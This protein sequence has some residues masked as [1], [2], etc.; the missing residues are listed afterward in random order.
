M[1]Q[2]SLDVSQ[3]RDSDSDVSIFSGNT[4]VFDSDPV[5][6]RNPLGRTSSSTLTTREPDVGTFVDLVTRK[7]DVAGEVT[8]GTS[9]FSTGGG[10]SG[11]GDSRVGDENY[12]L[13]YTCT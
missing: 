2:Q 10:A 12:C 8:L 13:K 6:D 7:L 9:G 5:Y 4:S 3:L 11:V 1:K